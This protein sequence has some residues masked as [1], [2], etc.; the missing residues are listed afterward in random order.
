MAWEHE[1]LLLIQEHLRFGFLDGFMKAFTSLGNAGWFFIVLGILLS[2]YP[3]TRKY[4]FLVLLSLAVDFVI[5]NLGVKVAVHRMRPYDRYMDLIPLVGPEK[6]FSFPS[7]HAGCAFA[8]AGALFLNLPKERRFFGVVSLVFAFLMGWSRLYVGVHYPT[9][10]IA[11][12]VIGFLCAVFVTV[13]WKRFLTG[14]GKKGS[15]STAKTQKEP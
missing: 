7:G 9:D 11:G 8:T 4:G 6:D 13:L 2:V 3:K 10:V 14:R 12:M 1:F 5:L 15:G